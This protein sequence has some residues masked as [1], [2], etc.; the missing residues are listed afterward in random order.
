MATNFTQDDLA[1]L[2][3]AISQN[4]REVQYADGRRVHFSSWEDLIKRRNF[5]ARQVGENAGR[6]RMRT[7]VTKG[8]S[9]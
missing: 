6:Q 1:R 4:V 5:V 9:C 8:V 3:E 7:K 2:D